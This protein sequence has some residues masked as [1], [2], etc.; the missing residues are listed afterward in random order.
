MQLIKIGHLPKKKT[1]KKF[2]LTPFLHVLD[3]LKSLFHEI[4]FLT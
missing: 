3:F 2:R 4:D 1:K